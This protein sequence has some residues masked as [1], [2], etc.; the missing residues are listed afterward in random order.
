MTQHIAA[1]AGKDAA[2][3]TAAQAFMLECQTDLYEFGLAQT[4]ELRGE[5]G[6][7][8]YREE[9][10]H[11][12]RYMVHRR[13]FTS[14]NGSYSM[15]NPATD[16]CM[17]VSVYMWLAEMARRAGISPIFETIPNKAFSNTDT[18]EVEWY[19]II[20][21]VPP[22]LAKDFNDVC[23]AHLTGKVPVPD[24]EEDEAASAPPRRRPGR[25]KKSRKTNPDAPGP[26][27][28]RASWRR[29]TSA[30]DLLAAVHRSNMVNDDDI[31][32]RINWDVDTQEMEMSEAPVGI[33]TIPMLFS[34]ELALDRESVQQQ[35]ADTN[36]PEYVKDARTYVDIEDGKQFFTV[37][38]MVYTVA[39][40]TMRRIHIA[41]RCIN[42]CADSLFKYRLPNSQVSVDLLRERWSKIE[43]FNGRKRSHQSMSDEEF[44]DQFI[45][46]NAKHR[47]YSHSVEVTCKNPLS[48][49]KGITYSAQ[50]KQVLYPMTE[51]IAEM[52]R[53][54]KQNVMKAVENGDMASTEL[55]RI[56]GDVADS[57]QSE[58]ETD[59]L[60]TVPYYKE[61]YEDFQRLRRE[62]K[63]DNK[64][65]KMARALL[66]YDENASNS[67]ADMPSF[68]KGLLSMSDA[69]TNGHNV[70]PQ[71]LSVVSASR[72]CTF[73]AASLCFA[74]L[75]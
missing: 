15:V 32:T 16:A 31:V 42:P 23:Q 73:G 4:Q 20:V 60:G 61:V 25:P 65:A 72:S 43:A 52:N 7:D 24:D 62:I 26:N 39:P 57:V 74:A 68:D 19:A 12:L 40:W 56:H 10:A 41:D 28:H 66:Y 67:A 35:L 63:R 50:W 36:V 5:N 58:L 8:D 38:G 17:N 64:I 45:G 37:P 44:M 30:K 54:K 21:A 34:L 22:H 53:I 6:Y 46:P 11:V 71:Q 69:I 47:R 27:T 3:L 14:T 2:V 29:V 55:F 18:K 51:E 48:V 70:T 59:T 13:N 9:A 33:N 1:M 75:Q 49:K